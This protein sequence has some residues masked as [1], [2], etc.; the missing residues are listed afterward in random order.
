MIHRRRFLQCYQFSFAI[1]NFSSTNLPSL[2]FCDASYARSYFQPKT[3][4]QSEQCT[5]ATVWRPVMSCL[6]SLGPKT[7]LVAWENRKARPLVA[8]KTDSWSSIKRKN[9]ENARFV[10]VQANGIKKKNHISTSKAIKQ[11]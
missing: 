4:R 3:S 8:F 10:C 5:S 2:Y 1:L 6:S 11:M 7:M 9:V